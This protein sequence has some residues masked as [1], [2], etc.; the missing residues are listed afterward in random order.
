[1]KSI[2]FESAQ[3]VKIEYELASVGQRA[4]AAII[5]FV[6]FVIYF[7]VMAMVLGLNDFFPE[8]MGPQM[9]VELLVI[10]LP[11]IFYHPLIEYLT[12]GQSLGKYILG[13]RVVTMTGERPGLREVFTRWIFKGDFIWISADILVLVWFII[14]IMGILFAGTSP[15][16]QRIGDAM[17]NVIVIKNKSSIQYTL[18]DVLSIKNQE[19]YAPVY[20]NA[21][22]FTDEDMLLIKNAIQRVRSN[23]NPENKRF[24]IELADESARLLGLPETPEKRMQ[25]LQT[26][27]QDY[28]VLTR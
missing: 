10:K 18:R 28:V 4:A 13:I 22:R 21:I 16:N 2:E 12:Q 26:L 23:P 11:F 27:L 25:F 8:S 19:N 5:D 7:V 14:P 6:A 24:A 20:P 9:F 3:N 1:M 15:L 17:A